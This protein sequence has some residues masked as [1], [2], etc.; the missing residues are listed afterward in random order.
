M[1]KTPQGVERIDPKTALEQNLKTVQEE[2][3]LQRRDA[4]R[5][6]AQGMPRVQWSPK[7]W[8]SHQV[9]RVGNTQIGHLYAECSSCDPKL[10]RTAGTAP[11]DNEHNPVVQLSGICN[12]IQQGGLHAF[13][14][15]S[16]GKFNL[17]SCVEQTIPHL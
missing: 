4:G 10:M 9:A 16:D 5:G 6:K 1:A 7:A 8:H 2:R 14:L 11:S 13:Q 15:C 17:R 3:L 12:D